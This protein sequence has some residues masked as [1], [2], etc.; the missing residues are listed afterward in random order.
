M[1][2]WIKC[3]LFGIHNWDVTGGGGNRQDLDEIEEACSVC[4]ETR[5]RPHW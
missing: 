5:T 4:G 1:W 3:K 2:N